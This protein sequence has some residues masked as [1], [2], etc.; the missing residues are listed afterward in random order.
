MN[1]FPE[2][3]ETA[4]NDIGRPGGNATHHPDLSSCFAIRTGPVGEPTL[5]HCFTA[6]KFVVTAA[7]LQEAESGGT[8]Q[9]KE[10]WKESVPTPQSQPGDPHPLPETAD[11]H[12]V[13]SA[14][15]NWESEMV[16]CRAMGSNAVED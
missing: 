12:L 5:L 9:E 11:A 10:H 7:A 15:V 8:V 13:H 1:A 14:A 2:S 6:V 16:E 4:H 3:P